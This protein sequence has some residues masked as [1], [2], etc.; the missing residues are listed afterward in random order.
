MKEAAVANGVKPVIGAVEMNME[1]IMEAE[2]TVMTKK[3]AMDE[4]AP[5]AGLKVIVDN[6]TL[7][8]MVIPGIMEVAGE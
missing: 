1:V 5:A 3:A 4:T 7:I 8:V 2:V 6:R